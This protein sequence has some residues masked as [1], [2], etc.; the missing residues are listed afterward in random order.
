MAL[1]SPRWKFGIKSYRMERLKNAEALTSAFSFGTVLNTSILLLDPGM[2]LIDRHS[3][4][5]II[6]NSCKHKRCSLQSPFVDVLATAIRLNLI[7]HH[8]IAVDGKSPAKV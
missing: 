8:L 7:K 5:T 6:M 2:R 1:P 4:S 3:W